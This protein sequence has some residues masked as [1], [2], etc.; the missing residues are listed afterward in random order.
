[1]PDSTTWRLLTMSGTNLHSGD[2]SRREIV[3]RL[4][5]LGC[6]ASSGDCFGG[7]VGG[8]D[9][10]DDGIVVGGGG[11]GGECGHGIGQDARGIGVLAVLVVT[12]EEEEVVCVCDRCNGYGHDC[13]GIND[14][15]E[16]VCSGGRNGGGGGGGG[17]KFAM[18]WG[19][20]DKESLYR[21]VAF[22]HLR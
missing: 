21:V 17:T 11:G 7:D 20:A 13:L 12:V 3:L 6:V 4:W 22:S 2:T 5:T 9:D 16:M 8:R 18:F 15:V 1:M 14:E 19:Y 10:D